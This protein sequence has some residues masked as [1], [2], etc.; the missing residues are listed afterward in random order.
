MSL[1]R[2]GIGAVLSER[3]SV[4]SLLIRAVFTFG[5][6]ISSTEGWGAPPQAG[7]PDRPR[8]APTVSVTIDPTQDRRPLSPLIFG[9]NWGSDA[10]M[11]R[12]KWPVRRWGGTP[13]SRYNWQIDADNRGNDWF[14]LNLSYQDPGTLPDGSAA[15]RFIDN[16]RAA[17]SEPFMTIPILGFVAKS[18]NW[19]YAFS[20]TRY[21]PQQLNECSYTGND[22][23]DCNP[24][25][26][27]GCQPGDPNGPCVKLTG[28]DPLDTSVAVTPAF[29]AGWKAH[30]AGRT[31][32]ASEGGVRF[33]G[34]DNEPS[35][36]HESHRDVH[37]AGISYDEYWQRVRDYAAALKNSDPAANVI[38]MNEWGWCGWLYS[39]ADN[40][41]AGPDWTAHGSLPITAWI[42]K[43]AREYEDANGVRLLDYISLHIYP[44]GENVAMTQDESEPTAARRLR[45]LKELYDRDWVSESWINDKIYLIPRMR[46]WRDA[47]YPGT[48]LAIGEYNFGEG[49]ISSA[50]AQAEALAIFAREGADMAMRWEAP[51]ENS[52]IEDAFSLFMN[53]D[54]SGSKVTGDAVRC[55]SSDV[56]AVGAYALAKPGSGTFVLLFNKDTQVRTVTVT[57]TGQAFR[58][59][60]RLYRFDAATRLSSAGTVA[61]SGGGLTLTLPA[62][63]ATLAVVARAYYLQ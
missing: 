62:R 9:V 46:D 14:F 2:N 35:L 1:Q 18:R 20:I 16:T 44:Q 41:W 17:G 59:S 42:L 33:F 43:K 8:L 48:K 10:Q 51:P 25:M 28:N 5:L 21:G 52:L 45:A 50:L 13:S 24:D 37:P 57:V 4:C 47:Q 31:G 40:C 38:G 7:K 34:L 54:G 22:P 26:G 3:I 39:A 19:N 63:S 32:L 11:N 30:I 53:Y 6:L 23:P 12:M 15:D 29:M 60:A 27:N 49:G 58:G 55:L 36:W 56:D 61:T